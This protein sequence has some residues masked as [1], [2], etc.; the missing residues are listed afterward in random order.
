MK[1]IDKSVEHYCR[2]AEAYYRRHPRP[3]AMLHKPFALLLEASNHLA[4]LAPLLDGLQLAKTMTVLDF[5]AGTCWLSRYLTHLGCRTICLDVSATALRLGEEMFRAWPSLDGPREEPQF[6][7]F[8]GH[9]IDLPDEYVDRVVCFEALHHVPNVDDVIAEIYRVLRPGGIAG[10]AEPGEEH[11]NTPSAQTEMMNYDILEL[12]IMV[13]NIW[14]TAE[15]LGFSDIRFRPFSYPVLDLSFDERNSVIAGQ[16]PPHLVKHL[17]QSMYEWSIF[18]LY[19]GKPLRDSR[20][21]DGLS[22]Q[23]VVVEAPAEVPAGQPF[24]VRVRCLN[25]GRAVWLACDTHNDVGTV[26]L[27]PHLYDGEMHLLQYEVPRF[28]L[29][30]NVGPGETCE[31]VAPLP[32]LPPGSYVF[33]FDLVAEDVIWFEVAGTIPAQVRVSVQ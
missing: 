13:Q 11:S 23:I 15:R 12:S 14:K 32:A 22:A 25:T 27:G 2:T 30:R 9:R 20:A 4:K 18:F 1:L 24:Q 33:T 26:K 17:A 16:P 21:P 8:N 31:A 28:P 5:G 19:K 29:P 6:L 7:V 3:Q 10:F